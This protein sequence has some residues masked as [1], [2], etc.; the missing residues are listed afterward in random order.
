[1]LEFT[2]G[3]YN[4]VSGHGVKRKPQMIAAVAMARTLRWTMLSE[5]TADIDHPENN[6]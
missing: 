6:L 5:E 2:N 3:H 1:V 4:V